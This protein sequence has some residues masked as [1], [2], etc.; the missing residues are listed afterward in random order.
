MFIGRHTKSD[1]GCSSVGAERASDVDRENSATFCSP[2]I[3]LQGSST[4]YKMELLPIL[5]SRRLPSSEVGG[6][7]ADS[8]AVGTNQPHHRPNYPL[9]VT[10]QGT[11][12][13]VMR[14][15]GY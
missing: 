2:N 8:T 15:V 1:S 5:G 4:D 10:A 7:F 12:L 11:M 14:R 13:G 9:R 6:S 3:P